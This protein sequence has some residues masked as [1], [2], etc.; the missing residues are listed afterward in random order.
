M[1]TPALLDYVTENWHPYNDDYVNPAMLTL[2]STSSHAG[3]ERTRAVPASSSATQK[4][5]LSHPRLLAR[6]KAFTRTDLGS[7]RLSDDA[8]IV[9]L[10][11]QKHLLRAFFSAAALQ[12]NSLVVSA[13][14][15]PL[16]CDVQMLLLGF[17]I[18][19]AIASD[20]ASLDQVRQHRLTIPADCLAAFH[21]LIG[22]LPGQKS[23]DLSAIVELQ[24]VRS[25][26]IAHFDR[27]ATL[28]PAGQAASL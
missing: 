6:L 9:G 28:T 8:F 24:I 23:N 7:R 20:P 19:S 14:S 21:R 3:T 13:D 18:R 26:P 15:L 17:G 22:L 5:T 25:L 1:K 16:L 2:Q 12:D 10:P 4:R 11:A 27:V